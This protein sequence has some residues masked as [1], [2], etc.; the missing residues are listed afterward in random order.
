MKLEIQN[1]TKK[2]VQTTVLDNISINLISGGVNGL[3]GSNGAGKTTLI[4]ILTTLE[5]P[6]DGQVLLDGVDITKNPSNIRQILGYLPQDVN[7]YPHLKAM[8]YLQYFAGIK[9]IPRKQSKEQIEY[10]LDFFGLTRHKKKPLGTYSGG[11]KQRIGLS[12]ALLGDPKVIIFDEPSVGLDPEERIKIRNLFEE[13][14]KERIV[15][16]STH[17][18]SDIELTAKNIVAMQNGHLKFTGTKEEFTNLGNGDFEQAYLKFMNKETAY[19][20]I[21]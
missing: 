20:K 7:V 17:I 4:K 14:A 8:E 19:A 13:L 12:C 15:L 16:L 5:A 18:I 11:M 1:V 9:G 10:L 2:Y 21:I 3:V 6:T